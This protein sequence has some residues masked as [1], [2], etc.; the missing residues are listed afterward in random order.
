MV[1]AEQG[2]G[3]FPP[4]HWTMIGR[5]GNADGPAAREALARLLEIYVPALRVHLVSFKRL[6]PT[7][8]DD[9]VQSF[10]AAK[11]LESSLIAGADR[12]RGKF[13][14]L[15]LTSLDRFV[16]SERRKQSAAKRGGNKLPAIDAT[17]IDI[18]DSGSTPPCRAFDVA[19]ARE[20]LAEVLR[21]MR[22]ECEE[23]GRADLWTVFEGR[24]LQPLL[25][26]A[27]PV[28]YD[29]LVHRFGYASPT[30]AANALVTA[31]RTFQRVLR[32][33]VAE[34]AR[35]PEE[36]DE[37]IQDLWSVLAQSGAES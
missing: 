21:R 16:I 32:A 5:A 12:S 37:E 1:P 7:A 9:L 33:A 31:K 25:N 27:A 6:D 20:L 10:V 13:R 4:T 29:E 15:L 18:P 28:E 23:S 22:R 24:L 35:S 19:W 17:E 30:Q 2:S 8:A 3:I 34:Y 26:D 11:I 14:T 36:I